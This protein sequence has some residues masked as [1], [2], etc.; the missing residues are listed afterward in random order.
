[1]GKLVKINVRSKGVTEFEL[2]KIIGY[3][4][5]EEGSKDQPY[6]LAGS[7]RMEVYNTVDEL[8]RILKGGRWFRGDNS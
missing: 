4:P 8:R 7:G 2:D 1:M 3:G 6:I 5:K